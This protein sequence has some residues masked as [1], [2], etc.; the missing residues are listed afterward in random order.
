VE[1]MA[2]SLSQLVAVF[3]DE[4]AITARLFQHLTDASLGQRVTPQDRSLGEIAWHIVTSIPGILGQVGLSVPGPGH[5]D[6][7]PACARELAEAYQQVAQAAAQAMKGSWTDASLEE[8]HEVYGFRWTKAQVVMAL[9][10]HQTHHRGAMTVLMR[11]AGL[12]L[13]EIYGPT[14]DSHQ[15]P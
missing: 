2:Q 6:P 5:K 10:F 12:S 15:H 9:L 7:V 1:N 3:S 4:A 14:R 8:V 11:Q 13:P